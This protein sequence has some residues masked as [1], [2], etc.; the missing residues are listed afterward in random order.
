[1][2][3]MTLMERLKSQWR[4]H[5]ASGWAAL[6]ATPPFAFLM[7]LLSIALIAIVQQLP[8]AWFTE[9]PVQEIAA[10]VVLAIAAGTVLVG[11]RWF[12]ETLPLML[13]VLVWALFLRELHFEFMNGGILFALAG[14]AW[15]LS[16]VRL[17]IADWLAHFWIRFWLASAFLSYFISDML[18]R[19]VF[20][21]LPN[22]RSW[23]N[24]VEESLETCG[25]VMIFA[26]VLA[27]IR[28]GQNLAAKSTKPGDAS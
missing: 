6:R 28:A 23:N 17:E 3:S 7:P 2:T 12:R 8:F 26:L 21:F 14:L 9:K 19:H 20:S 10:P 4:Q 1:M 5:Y 25:H 15:W 27:T 11:Y 13:A 22:Y 24:N 18:D 16:T